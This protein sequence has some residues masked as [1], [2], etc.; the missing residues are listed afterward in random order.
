MDL[1]NTKLDFLSV[2]L[3]VCQKMDA[4]VICQTKWVLTKSRSNDGAWLVIE[5]FCSFYRRFLVS[6]LRGYY[7]PRKLVRSDVTDPETRQ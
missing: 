1:L 5:M 7:V 3:S 6:T 2:C 4:L